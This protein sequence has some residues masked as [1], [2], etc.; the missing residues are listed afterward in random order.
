[1]NFY[2]EVDSPAVYRPLSPVLL[3]R[4]ELTVV[5]FWLQLIAI[6]MDMITDPHILQD[7]MDAASGRSVPVYILLDRLGVP[8]FLDMC[9][10]L[11][12]GSKHLQVRVRGKSA[13]TRTNLSSAEFC[14]P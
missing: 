5:F 11:Q 12:I 8:H 6:V 13:L 4:T 10:R 2:L 7:L 3:P 9:N 14:L 1:M